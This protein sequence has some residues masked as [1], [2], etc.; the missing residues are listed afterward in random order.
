MERFTRRASGPG[1]LGHKV[2]QKLKRN[3]KLV[4]NFLTLSCRKVRI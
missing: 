1:S 2:P 4:Y 3:V